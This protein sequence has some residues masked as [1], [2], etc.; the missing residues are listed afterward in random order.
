M[1]TCSGMATVLSAITELNVAKYRS[2]ISTDEKG[3]GGGGG[4]GGRGEGQYAPS[5]NTTAVIHS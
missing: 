1:P 4:G 3:G 5:Q 2:F